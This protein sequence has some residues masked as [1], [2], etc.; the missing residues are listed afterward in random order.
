MTKRI[1]VI[2][3][4]R[5]PFLKSGTEF[6]ELIHWLLGRHAVKGLIAKTGISSKEID[7]V[8][9]GS[10]FHHASTTNVAREVVLASGLPESLPAH[11]CTVA[12]ISAN[13]AVT[14]GVGLIASGEADTVIAGGI[15]HFKLDTIPPLMEFS[16]RL[17]MGQTGDLLA[18]RLSISRQNQD[19]YAV[20]SHQRA[21]AARDRGFFKKDI[22]PVVVHD[23]GA[24]VTEDNGPRPDT[25]IDKMAKLKGAFDPE[26]G[27]VTAANSTF[28]TDGATA[29]LIMSEE[30]ALSLGL[31][32]KAY[33]KSFTYT[34][35]NP[36]DELLLG[37]AFAIPKVLAKAGL[38]LK[39]IGVLEIH[40]A[41][42]VQMLA[43]MMMLQ[44]DAFAREKLGLPEKAGEVDMD[45]LNK[46]GGSLSLGHPFGATGGRLINT[47][48]DRMVEE[49]AEFG[50]VAGCAAGAVGS[51]ILLEQAQC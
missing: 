49:D 13:V 7:H 21:I 40:E 41:F 23:T 37:P 16:T 17:L 35:Q 36:R 11:T 34:A 26:N 50:I 39:D 43:N 32:P 4:C 25:S 47:C 44:S 24:T 9:M 18:Q 5:T 2:D 8:I 51:A 10:L 42:S 48:C 19:A 20:D 15:E 3:G 22:V 38:K 45:R 46:N 28:L 14:N 30:K 1:A 27:T 12:C 6:K 31:K 29:V 33:I